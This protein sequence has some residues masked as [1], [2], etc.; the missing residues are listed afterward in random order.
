MHNAIIGF[1]VVAGIFVCLEILLLVWL[2]G[3]ILRI[4]RQNNRHNRNNLRSRVSFNA[5]YGDIFPPKQRTPQD[6]PP[7][8]SS[9]DPNFLYRIASF[10]SG[11]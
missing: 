7:V 4:D 8:V 2:A 5:R 6:D 3:L 10:R 11:L 1:L 9:D